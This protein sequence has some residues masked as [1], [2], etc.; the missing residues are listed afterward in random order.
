MTEGRQRLFFALWP[1]PAAR[2]ALVATGRRHLRGPGRRVAPELLHA[3]VLF[4]GSIDREQRACLEAHAGGLAVS[5]FALELRRVGSWSRSRVL[6]AAPEESPA[7][8]LELSRLLR[9]AALAC[10]LPVEERGFSAHVTL[11][12]KV[13]RRHPPVDIPPISW[14]VDRFSLVASDTLPEGPRYEVVA[15]WPLASGPG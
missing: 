10:G 6:W 5:A 15:Q 1:D 14:E 2:Q 13:A 4:L 7:P 11:A 3:T 9:S 12:R 8:L